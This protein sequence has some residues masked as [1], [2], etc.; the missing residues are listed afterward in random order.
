MS[1]NN[2]S[3]KVDFLTKSL[4]WVLFLFFGSLILYYGKVFFTPLLF[5][6]L[7]AMIMFPACKKMEQ[8]GI[9]RTFSIGI[10]LLFITLLIAAIIWLLEVQISIFLDK[11]PL[12]SERLTG[13]S[14][15][16]ML[17]LE[18]TFGITT[19]DQYV[20]FKKFIENPEN[21][22]AKIIT[23]IFSATISTFVLLLLT[24][25]FSALFLY[26]RDT[27][28]RFL[29]S[30]TKAD[31]HEKLHLIVNESILSY[32]KFAK[33]TFYVYCIV[34]ILNSIGL[35][36]LGI[37]N[38][39]V[40]GLIAALMTIIPYIGVF[41]SAAIPVS[42]AYLTK[43]STWYPIGVVAIFTVVQYLEANVI[44]PKV[45]GAQLNLSTWATLCGIVVGT[46]IWGIAGM[47][48]I[49]PLL[50]I[51]KIVSDYIPE[52]KPLNLL[53]NRAEGYVPK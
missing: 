16:A 8:K 50:A 14:K 2:P 51:L 3:Q 45:V 35:L 29:E 25:I 10:S 36:L 26:H 49:T 13:T 27:F 17:W 31:Y 39:I 43:D 7:I 42:I 34:G 22:L 46:I 44:Y 5:G 52:W 40:Y 18:T 21:N 23:N 4:K 48:L 6:L 19:D 20:F 32:L 11:L 47:I 53:L 30:I 41:I 15:V 28:I 37:E 12:L 38:A 9:S 33:G 1:L 24:P